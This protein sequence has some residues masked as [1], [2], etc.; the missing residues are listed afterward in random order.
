MYYVSMS[1]IFLPKKDKKN[2]LKETSKNC[3]ITI[4]TKGQRHTYYASHEILQYNPVSPMKQN[5][6]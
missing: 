4:M 2:Q 1:K 6:N 3:L 5:I